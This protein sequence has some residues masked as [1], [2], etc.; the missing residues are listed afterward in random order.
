[1]SQATAVYR[2]RISLCGELAVDL[3]GRRLEEQL[4]GGRECALFGILV[5]NRARALSRDELIEALWEEN[6][7]H[8]PGAALSTVLSRLRRTLG[9][10]VLRGRSL[11]SVCLPADAWIDVEAAQARVSE[12]RTALEAGDATRCLASAVGAEEIS[13]RRLLPAL[14]LEWLEDARRDLGEVRLRALE[15]IARAGLAS[16]S[17]QLDQ[18]ERAARALLEEQPY[19]E[20]G[21]SLL[22]EIHAAR[23]D[24]AEALQVYELL[25]VL[26]REE[27]GTSPAAGIVELHQRLLTHGAGEG[28]GLAATPSAPAPGGGE[29][30]P[31][32]RP[33]LPSILERVSSQPFVGREDQLRHLGDRWA[34]TA[35]GDGRLLLIAGEPGMGKTFL[36]ARFARAAFAAGGS[37]LYGRAEE[38]ALVPYQ[39]FVEALRHHFAHLD[40]EHLRSH[41][42]VGAEELARFLPELR[43]RLPELPPAGDD[44]RETARYRLFEAV[45]SVFTTAAQAQ[46]LLL[47]LD[48][49]H[50]ADRPTLLFLR[51]L[52]RFPVES[53]LLVLGV[54]RDVEVDRDHPLAELIAEVRR[55]EPVDRLHLSGLDDDDVARLVAASSAPD[56]ALGLLGDL[57][58]RTGGNPF[59]IGQILSHAGEVS[60]REGEAAPSS[61]PAGRPG[62][63][64]PP[65][66]VMEVIGRRI[67]RLGD[68]ARGALAVAAVIGPIFEL[69]LVELVRGRPSLAA[70]DGA[71]VSHLV[72]ETEVPGRYRFAH[73]LV[74]ETLYAELTTTR[75]A[76]L[77]RRVGEELEQLLGPDSRERAAEL[78]HHFIAGG[79]NGN[80]RTV[81]HAARAG[82]HA[83]AVFAYEEAARHYESALAGLSSQTPVDRDRRAEI[84]LALGWAR[85]RSGDPGA[86]ATFEQAGEEARKR[87]DA[88]GL[89]LA[90]LG[91][92]R[93]Y[94]ET[95]RF[96]EGLISLLDEAL[97]ALP[98][99][100]HPL[101]AQV[102]ARL[103]EAVYFSPRH[104]EAQELSR[105]A[106]E[107]A[108][109][110]AEPSALIPAMLGRG[111]ALGHVD[112]LDERL[113]L[114]EE[115]LDLAA[116]AGDE[117]LAA[118]GMNR[119]VTDLMEAGRL[120]EAESCSRALREL[121]TR[122]R[123]PLYRHY[124]VGWRLLWARLAGRF[125]EAERLVQESLALGQEAQ[126]ADV[127]NI[128]AAQLFQLR[129]DQGRLAELLP[130]VKNYVEEYPA[131]VAWRATLAIVYL[132]VGNVDGARKLFEHFARDDFASVPRDGYWLTGMGVLAE[133][134]HGLGDAERAHVLYDL[135]APYAKLHLQVGRVAYFGPIERFLALVAAASDRLETADRHFLRAREGCADLDAPTVSARIEHEHGS[136]L[137]R[138]GDAGDRERGEGLMR[139]ARATAQR[140]GMGGVD[141]G[142]G[143]VSK[144]SE[145]W[146]AEPG[147][148]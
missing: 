83:T 74:Q 48:D 124:A 86:R 47:V 41:L 55:N 138:L 76:L 79:D 77:H 128:A 130:L 43:R 101:R 26:L 16:G 131:L 39:P 105:S 64:A 71:V 135:L 60:A 34:P 116:R 12:A 7:P 146:R 75:R 147:A 148:G 28:A 120:E 143:V 88:E 50:W 104:G 111:F 29:Q 123:Q 66:G 61:E 95:G 134:C 57:H 1:M 40:E 115:L 133:A 35:S 38:D 117:E 63:P 17:R 125:D 30:R 70:F 126:L 3:E 23:G 15:L 119:R 122:L 14:E 62:E 51:H 141:R 140:L 108:R 90:A 8:S 67:G 106:C 42:P 100:A 45:A 46:P 56:V 33:P 99:D 139:S 129:R 54:Y 85:C 107:L 10:G 21:Y 112:G 59:F 9:E 11:V 144:T 72:D 109:T 27:L 84:L 49:L 4:G 81:D 82:D 91:Y 97:G 22:M 89:A 145:P 31:P 118:E 113:T 37:V 52:L 19:R 18:A 73:A 24:V 25:R 103:S 96:D 2:T 20:T 93:Q 136:A 36:A 137:V 68:D 94:A 121:A 87:G 132:E 78:A 110:I 5:L 80:T 142:A 65:E 32:E 98:G 44:D 92:G 127:G 102:L 6:P 53:R 58:R 114:G 69:E 13:S